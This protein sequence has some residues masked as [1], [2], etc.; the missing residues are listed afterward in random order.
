MQAEF[1][2]FKLDTTKWLSGPLSR[3]SSSAKGA[4]MDICSAYWMNNTSLTKDEITIQFGYENELIELS[5]AKVLIIKNDMISI[6]DLDSQFDELM[7]ERKFLSDKGK[8]GVSMKSMYNK[9]DFF[10]V[11]RDRD[12]N[13]FN[14][15]KKYLSDRLIDIEKPRTQREFNKFMTSKHYNIREFTSYMTAMQMFYEENHKEQLNNK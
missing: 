1:P 3:R 6:P 8:Y 2:F 13:T 15:C 12:L 11:M 10:G 9:N 14:G 4:F 7:K 5:S